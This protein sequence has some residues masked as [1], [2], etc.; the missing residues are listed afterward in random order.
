MQ[1]YEM[2]KKNEYGRYL[3]D[4]VDGKYIEMLKEL[5]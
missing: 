4:V 5:R 3:K 1:A 2:M